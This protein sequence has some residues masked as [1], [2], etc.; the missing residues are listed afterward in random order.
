MLEEVPTEELQPAEAHAGD[1]EARSRGAAAHEQDRR[2]GRQ[3]LR[4]LLR[5]LPRRRLPARAR[6]RR[7][8]NC[9]RSR[10]RSRPRT[11]LAD[12]LL[13]QLSLQT[14]DDADARDRR[15][16]SSATSTT[17][18][19]WWRRSRRSRRW[20]AG[21]SPRSSARCGWSRA[22]TRSAW[23]RA[24][25]RSACWLQL[26]HLG[27]EGT[28]TEKIVTEHLRL[29]QNHQVPG[30]GAQA[31][32][33]DRRAEGA[34]RDHPAPRS[35][36]GQPLQPA[37]VALRHPGR[38]RGQGRGPVRRGAER[39]G[40]AAAAHQPGLPAAAREGQPTTATRPARTSR[41][42]SGRRCG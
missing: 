28:P 34:H 41:T 9:R 29:L 5:R 7:S 21:R 23:P 30:A 36:A 3:R 35:E 12:H 27:L 24:T 22:S 15:R 42:S 18:A 4:V 25:C 13:W 38:L 2:L 1:R 39:G 32:A 33:V 8:R 40:A 37:A 31:R 19:T 11:S 26:R 16:R 6:R 20:A 14:D 17:T 10:T